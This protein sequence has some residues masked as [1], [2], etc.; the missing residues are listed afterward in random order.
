MVQTTPLLP[1]ESGIERPPSPLE[2]KQKEKYQSLLDYF[3]KQDYRLSG[4]DEDGELKEIEKFWLVLL[5][6]TKW[7][8]NEAQKRLEDTLQWRREFGIYD[9]TPEDIEPEAVTGKEVLLGYDNKKQPM[10]YMFPS[11]QNTE[12]SPRQIQFTFY[13]F[14]LSMDLMPPG[15]EAHYP[16][17]LGYAYISNVPF[18]VRTFFTLIS[19]FIDPISRE[20]MKFN[21]KVIED[22]YINPD[23]L[24]KEWGGQ[25]DFEYKHEEYWPN[26]MEM[27]RN[28]RNLWFKNWQRMGG[29]IGTSEWDMKQVSQ[30]QNA[31]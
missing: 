13:F 2:D 18:L 9:I 19:P 24:I 28:R 22:G 23:Q 16:E 14:E 29:K 3:S 10:F 27:T 15:I 17:R 25:I 7:D 20:K 31:E 8:V 5:R 11:R 1:P 12:E 21:P 6:A 30:E 26:L 4:A